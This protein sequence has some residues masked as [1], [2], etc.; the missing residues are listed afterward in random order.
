[1]GS[2][3]D[4]GTY[5]EEFA[6][7]LKPDGH[8]ILQIPKP[9][10]FIF[11][12]SV[13]ERPGYRLLKSDPVGIRNGEVLRVFEDEREIQEAFG[14]H[15]TSFVTGSLEDD[16]FGEDMHAFLVVCVKKISCD[17]HHVQ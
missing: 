1:M 15:F 2:K 8:L 10:C 3:R 14:A 6:R 11:K 4:F 13:P 7:V 16:C 9:T 12:G 5:V 17:Y